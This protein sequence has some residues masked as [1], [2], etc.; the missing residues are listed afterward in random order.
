MR[1]K[2]VCNEGSKIG[3]VVYKYFLCECK[4]ACASPVTIFAIKVKEILECNV[5][6]SGV[7]VR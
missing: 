1:G 4:G 5:I 2:L 3:N 6:W 7:L